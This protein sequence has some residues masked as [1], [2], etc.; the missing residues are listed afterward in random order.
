MRLMLLCAIA[1]RLPIAMDSSDRTTSMSCQPLGNCGVSPESGCSAF[2]SS[3]IAIANAASLGPVLMKSVTAEG[4]PWYTSGI[5][6]WNGTTPTLNAS[7]ETMNTSPKAS[8]PFK[9]EG[10]S[11]DAGRPCGDLGDLER[12]R[13]EIGRAHV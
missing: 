6:M 7:P 13:G 9:F 4:A 5:H 11:Q 1:A 2:T 3:R 10:S 12:A 8:T